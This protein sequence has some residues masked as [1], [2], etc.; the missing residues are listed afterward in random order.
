M[1]TYSVTVWSDKVD[2]TKLI[3]C[4][5]GPNCSKGGKRYPLDNSI[6]FDRVYPPVSDLSGD[7]N[8]SRD[9]SISTYSLS[10]PFFE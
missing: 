2:H 6:G 8:S 5:P 7:K 9:A 3:F 4:L 10:Q 1:V